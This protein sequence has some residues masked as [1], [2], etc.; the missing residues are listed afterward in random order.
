MGTAEQPSSSVA[1]PLYLMRLRPNPLSC[2]ARGEA[3]LCP[4]IF[5]LKLS[6]KFSAAVNMKQTCAYTNNFHCT[7][8]YAGPKPSKTQFLLTWS[9]QL[10]NGRRNMRKRKRRPEV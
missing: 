5:L 7:L 6:L 9:S 10:R 4:I 8:F 2:S 1:L 3:I